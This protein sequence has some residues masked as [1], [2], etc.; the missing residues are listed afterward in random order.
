MFE[1]ITEITQIFLLWPFCAVNTIQKC[2]LTLSATLKYVH[3][4]SIV[5][6]YTAHNTENFK[7]QPHHNDKILD[8]SLKIKKACRVHYC[9]LD[10][11]FSVI[12]NSVVNWMCVVVIQLW[13]LVPLKTTPV[14]WLQNMQTPIAPEQQRTCI[15]RSN[16]HC[17][18][19]YE[20]MLQPC[21][22]LSTNYIQIFCTMCEHQNLT[23][24]QKWALYYNNH[25][26]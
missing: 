23:T 25:H 18:L 8:S 3:S 16:K 19:N 4:N 22:V 20:H 2:H 14:C 24:G 21:D 7:F 15:Y 11:T 6:M 9:T 26:C 13:I 17:T 5:M 10:C 1:H 12:Q